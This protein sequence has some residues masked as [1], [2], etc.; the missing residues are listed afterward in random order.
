MKMAV[1]VIKMLVHT[2]LVSDVGLDDDAEWPSTHTRT[3][4]KLIRSIKYILFTY[5][6]TLTLKKKNPIAQ[7][8]N[9]A[10]STVA[11]LDPTFLT[12]Q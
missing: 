12:S 3:F 11:A 10:P 2:S 7:F 8:N 9:H 1:P 4:C 6:L 5:F